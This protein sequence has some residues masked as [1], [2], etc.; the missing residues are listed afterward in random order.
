MRTQQ[1]RDCED[2]DENNELYKYGKSLLDGND[3]KKSE[4]PDKD[5]PQEIEVG[6]IDASGFGGG[7]ACFTDKSFVVMGHSITLP[8]SNMCQYLEW[9]RY[10][11]MLIASIVSYR[12]LSGAILRD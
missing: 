4:L 2:H 1:T 11:I 7:G 12:I 5:H 8:L 6:N 10:A 9:L 3:P